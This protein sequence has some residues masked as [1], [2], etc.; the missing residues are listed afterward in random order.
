[1][2]VHHCT[3]LYR[4]VLT[5]HLCRRT[6]ATISVEQ[7]GGKKKCD[8][9]QQSQR[10]P[11]QLWQHT[12]IQLLI[13]QQKH[14]WTK[15]ERKTISKMLQKKT[16]QFLRRKRNQRIEQILT[17]LTNLNKF[18]ARSLD[19]KPVK[20]TPYD[21]AMTQKKIAQSFGNM[22]FF[23]DHGSRFSPSASDPTETVPTFPLSELKAAVSTLKFGRSADAHRIVAEMFVYLDD[24]LT[25]FL[26]GCGCCLIVWCRSRR[27][28]HLQTS[29]VFDEVLA[30]M[31]RWWFWKMFVANFGLIR[32]F[33]HCKH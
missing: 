20:G 19:W 15:E 16:R 25:Q 29:L 32:C 2:A 22:I 27:T 3:G 26:L 8:D 13:Q 9:Q 18:H 5:T 10:E 6:P 14:A 1:M 4:H 7:T 11:K 33:Q 12:E 17:E 24:Q 21:R 23:S 31:M 30:L 28:S